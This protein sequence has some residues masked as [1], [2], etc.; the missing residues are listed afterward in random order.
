MNTHFPRCEK[1]QR[2]KPKLAVYIPHVVFGSL[3][4]KLVFQCWSNRRAAT[5]EVCVFCVRVL[6]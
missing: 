3:L 6:S 4:L 1:T 2:I 5:I